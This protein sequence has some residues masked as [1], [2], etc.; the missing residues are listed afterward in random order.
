M[1]A[2]NIYTDYNLITSAGIPATQS[3]LHLHIHIVPRYENDGLHLPWTDQRR[4]V[5]KPDFSPKIFRQ[6]KEM[7]RRLQ[8]MKDGG[9]RV[10]GGMLPTDTHPW[11][12][13]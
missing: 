3:V 4:A 7:L 11:Q 13:H 6:Q 2:S 9:G 10:N 8:A 1:L 5:S 12:S